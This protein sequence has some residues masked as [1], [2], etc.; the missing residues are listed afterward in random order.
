MVPGELEIV[1]KRSRRME[2]GEKSKKRKQRTSTL[3]SE[4]QEKESAQK[5]GHATK[6]NEEASTRR[7]M[8]NPQRPS[9]SPYKEKAG[10]DTEK[11]EN[12]VDGESEKEEREGALQTQG[13]QKWKTSKKCD[14]AQV[15]HG[16][17]KHS[18]ERKRR[19]TRQE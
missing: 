5:R 18:N 17:T 10:T 1:Q 3:E 4:Q 12:P 6:D 11:R 19:R 9:I 15:R 14:R 16:E 13:G 8:T 7:N 2:R